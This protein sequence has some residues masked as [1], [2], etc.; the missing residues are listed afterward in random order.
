MEWDR[1]AD[2][3]AIPN[4]R[5]QRVVIQIWVVVVISWFDI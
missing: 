5:L 4:P 3:E 1:V 2:V